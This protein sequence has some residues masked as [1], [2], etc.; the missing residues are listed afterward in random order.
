[1]ARFWKEPYSLAAA[2]ALGIRDFENAP[3]V[4]VP[5]GAWV[6]RP[7][8]RDWPEWIYYVEVC[9]FTFAFFSLDMIREYRDFYS[10]KV[11]PSS[12]FFGASPF[13]RGAAASV[14]DGQTRFERLP[15]RLRKEAKRVR[16]VKA[17]ERALQLFSSESQQA[18]PDAAADRPRD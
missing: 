7:D 15:L 1:M 8:F 4:G 11:L 9:R 14:G 5:N 16:V 3:Y 12:R 13:S 6:G 18:E 10:R 2:L 17:L